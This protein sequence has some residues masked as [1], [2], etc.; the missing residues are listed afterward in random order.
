MLM[1]VKNA[2]HARGK[3]GTIA[4]SVISVAVLFAMPV[5]AQ[6]SGAISQSFFI[7]ANDIT[8]GALVS[9]VADKS[10]TVRLATVATASNLVGVVATAPLLSLSE[11]TNKVPVVIGGQAELLVSDINGEIRAGDKVTASPLAGVGMRASADGQVVGVAL[12]DFAESTTRTQTITD[13][14]GKQHDVRI[15]RVPVQVNV[16]YY[17]APSSGIVPPFLQN[18]ADTIAGRQVSVVRVLLA[19]GLV[20]VGLVGVSALLYSA[21]RSGIISIGRNPLAAKSIRRGVLQVSLTSLLVI[22]FVL[23]GAYLTLS[24]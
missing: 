11:E 24:I 12:G 13:S 20:L 10:D 2:G 6:S 23:T 16:T 8:D 17:L 7:N 9:V 3:L 15:G 21:A 18:L 14:Q 5:A 4:L 1:Y 22:L 19:A